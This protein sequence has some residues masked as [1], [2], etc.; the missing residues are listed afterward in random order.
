MNLTE[1]RMPLGSCHTTWSPDSMDESNRGLSACGSLFADDAVP[2][3]LLEPS[4]LV[5]L[6]PEKHRHPD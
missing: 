3:P 4:L 6:E 2:L 1:R 5:L